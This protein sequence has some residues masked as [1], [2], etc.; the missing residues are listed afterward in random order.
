MD[1]LVGRISRTWL[2]YQALGISLGLMLVIL[3]FVALA[4]YNHPTLDDFLDAVTVRKLGFWQS[5]KFF[6]TTLT[7]RYTTT[8]LLAVINPLVY[9]QSETSW[10][11]TLAFI[12]GTLVILRYSI[13]TLCGLNGITA[14]WAG[15]LLLSLWLAYAPG[16]AEGLYWFTG[17]Y[18][19]VVTAWLLL[20]WAVALGCYAR[21]RRTK[22]REGF[23][24]GAA[25]IL[26]VAVAGTTEP[27][28]LPFLL[29]LLF[30]TFLSTWLKRGRIVW[31]FAG[32]A[33]V[34]C[35]VSFLAPGNFV[36]MEFM[37]NHYGFFKT[38]SYSAATTAY[39]LLTWLANPVLLIITALVLPVLCRV[40]QNRDNVIVQHLSQIP[41]LFLGCVLI[42]L[43]VV[44][45]C[46]AYY[47]SG[48]G[49]PLRA[50]NMLY[51]LF[52]LGW[53]GTAL[54][55]CCR[56]MRLKA[57]SRT[58]LRFLQAGMGPV[59]AALLVLFFFA[60]YNFQ[61]RASQLGQSSN[62]VIRAYRQWLGGDAA[63]YD[64]ER[65][66]RYRLLEAGT[67]MVELMP[68]KHRPDLLFSFD[69]AEVKNPAM[70][71]NYAEYFTKKQE[72]TPPVQ[73]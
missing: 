45:S 21:A 48:T 37:G 53:F 60:D 73:P 19:Y 7:G 39:L 32:L 59:W 15:G 71:R 55:V 22:V 34:G 3:P 64:T 31:L 40:A 58:L 42:A 63:A 33:A 5:Q 23:W 2:R 16:H 66:D 54:V 28:A 69:I 29:A 67:P 43:L 50:R 70:L 61:T 46:P 4:F 30:G 8:V 57:P 14:W 35:V 52:I 12:L 36:R 68:L 24:L 62:N 65:R 26:T 72:F 9:G 44:A 11:V 1:F 51:L 47:A 20:I 25:C 41:P 17:A 18:T 27:V 56:Q 38:I 10:W 6:Y 49:L 13:S